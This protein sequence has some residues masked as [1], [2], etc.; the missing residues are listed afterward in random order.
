MASFWEVFTECVIEMDE[1][2][3][4]TNVRRKAGN[5]STIPGFVGRSF[6]DTVA[7]QDR[8]YVESMLDLLKNGE[9]PYARFHC[10]SSFGRYYRWTLKAFDEGGKFAGIHGVT[11][12]VTEQTLKEITLNWQHAV[13]EEGSSFVSIADMDGNVLYT[14]ARAYKMTGHDPDSGPLLP[15]RMFTPEY[16]TTVMGEGMEAV[17]EC[18]AWRGLGELLCLDG[19]KIPIEQNLFSIRN[20]RDEAILVVSVINDVTVFQEHERTLEKARKA[21]EAAN[22]AKSEFLSHMSHEIRTPMNA[23]IGMIG[24][25]LGADDVDR[26]DYCFRRAE[27]ASK[28]LLRIINDILDMSKIEAE[29]FELVN[30]VF[31]FGAL[32]DNIRNMASVRAEEKRQRLIVDLEEGVPA[33]I[34]GDELRLTQVITN[35]LMNAIKFTPESGTVKLCVKKAGETGGELTLQIEISDTGIGISK[36]QQEGLFSS[37]YQADS[38]IMRDFGGTGLGLAI[39]KKIVEMMGGRIWVESELGEGSTFIFTLIAKK[40]EGGPAEELAAAKGAGGGDLAAKRENGNDFRGRTV[41]IAEDVE[42]NREIMSA[43]LEETGISIEFAENGRQAVSMFRAKPEAY[44]L[45]LMDINMPEMDGYEA[46]RRIRSLGGERAEGVP[47]IAMTANVFREDIDKCLEAGM[48]NHIG[49][50]IEKDS[51]INLMGEYI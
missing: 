24:I 10:L 49:K 12:D 28:H 45:I 35:L 15:E 18:G 9:A 26:K 8:A 40:A 1:R 19:S 50:P 11:I 6:M 48:N 32:L 43:V 39:S 7:E 38:S 30:N 46:A 37:F 13:I 51:M 29:K 21:A 36:E 4:I 2:Y 16:F 47:I 17:L 22:I 41:L 20:E 42:I 14:N 31:D 33:F 3:V 5:D 23:I 34:S 27:S 44:D 25:G